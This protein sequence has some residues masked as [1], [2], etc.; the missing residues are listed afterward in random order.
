VTPPGQDG[1]GL[2]ET[3]NITTAVFAAYLKCPTKGLLIARGDKA[4]QTFFVGLENNIS[5]VY[6]AKF[7][8]TARFVISRHD[9]VGSPSIARI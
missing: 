8:S 9:V 5:E 7:G 4:P 1:G 2:V 3:D 6:K